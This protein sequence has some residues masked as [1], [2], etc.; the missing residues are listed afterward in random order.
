[1][2]RLL[3]F[4]FLVAI[5]SVLG[6]AAERKIEFKDYPATNI[7]VGKPAAVD[8]KSDPKARMY[9]TQLGTQTKEGANFA[10]HY[11]IVTW[12]CGAECEDFAIVDCKTGK[13]HFPELPYVSNHYW[14]GDDFGLDF[15]IN[16]RLLI[17]R[18]SRKGAR[19]EDAET[20]GAHYYLWDGTKLKL[21][22]DETVE[23]SHIH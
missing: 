9:R 6:S 10:G 2:K 1:M 7:F 3:S 19:K 5:S 13:V 15:R 21:I 23:P 16:S 22:R 17:L 11:H 20:N 18:G 12:G 4:G 14:R 8:L